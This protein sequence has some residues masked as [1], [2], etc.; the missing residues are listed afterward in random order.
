MLGRDSCSWSK[1]R[2]GERKDFR[3]GGEREREG[4]KHAVLN[5]HPPLSYLLQKH[6]VVWGVM[7]VETTAA[8]V[9]VVVVA[10]VMM[11]VLL[12]MVGM[13]VV[14]VVVVIMVVLRGRFASL[15]GRW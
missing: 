1:G 6:N 2:E 15:K 14:V 7:V 3:G 12:A 10:V 8:A 9:D 13:I 11:V 4:G 5:D